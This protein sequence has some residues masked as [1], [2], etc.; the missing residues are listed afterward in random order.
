MIV[1]MQLR[2]LIDNLMLVIFLIKF[3]YMYYFTK[4]YSIQCPDGIA[5]AIKLSKLWQQVN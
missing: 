4:Y 3:I 1:V 5:M 2:D